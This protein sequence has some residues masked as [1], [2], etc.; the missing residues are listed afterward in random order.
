[1]DWSR[2]NLPLNQKNTWL[3]WVQLAYSEDGGNK[4]DVKHKK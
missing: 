1:M 4:Y 3:V 2:D